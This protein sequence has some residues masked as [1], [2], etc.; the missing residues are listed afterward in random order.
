MRIG[1]DISQ[2]VYPGTG[3]GEYT[4][5]LVESLLRIDEKNEYILFFSSLRK[6]IRNW[7]LPCLPVG[8]KI[9]NAR[10]KVKQYKIPPTIL[11]ILWN[12]LHIAPIEWFI[13][14]VDVFISSDWTQP[15][16]IKAKQVTVIHDLASLKYPAEHHAKIVAVQRRRLK[17]V[18]KK[19]DLIICVSEA[20][21]KD[22]INLLGITE[23]KIR[24]IYEGGGQ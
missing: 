20:T 22:V 6:D 3:V 12:R 23:S 16:T 15:P 14:D 9:R 10:V 2:I 5:R 19:C 17:R 7:K 8:R 21:K 4:K 11:D 18:Q 24:V 1:I 13:G